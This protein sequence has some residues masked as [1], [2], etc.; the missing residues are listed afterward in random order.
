MVRW[1]ETGSGRERKGGR[2]QEAARAWR[3]DLEY[4][5]KEVPC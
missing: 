5:W 1:R 2:P 3:E 4:L